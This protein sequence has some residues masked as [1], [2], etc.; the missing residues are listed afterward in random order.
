MS[1][2]GGLTYPHLV[3]QRVANNGQAAIFV[4][5]V[6][7]SQARIMVRG[8]NN[9]FF[10]IS[11]VDFT[12]V[13]VPVIL[14]IAPATSSYVENAAPV[15]IADQTVVTLV[16]NM[17]GMQV[18]I[19]INSGAQTGD[20]LSISPV[21]G[22]SITNGNVD[23]NGTIF[24][25]V[26]SNSATALSVRLNNNSTNQTLEA[27]LRS[28]IFSN[29]TDNPR[30]VTRTVQFLFG[31]SAPQTVDIAVQ[32]TNDAP[33]L[34]SAFLASIPEDVALVSGQSI[35]QTVGPVFV[36]PMKIHD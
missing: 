4:P 18:D 7:T 19:S 21:N 29:T 6:G 33:V 3:A 1:A 22:I 11:D 2:D 5:N 8:N 15:L 17:V 25:T 32:P 30:S 31:G 12:V 23:I 9:I 34:G 36:D 28:V 27:F 35:A 24:A 10:D 14:T 13:P 26:I 16:Q 20:L